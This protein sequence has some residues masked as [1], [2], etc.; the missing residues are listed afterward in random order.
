M[1]G[2]QHMTATKNL[3]VPHPGEFLRDELE[4]RGWNQ[5][6]LAFVIG[7]PETGVNPIITGKRGI[8]PEMARL[9]GDAFDVSPE[10]WMNLQKMYDLE[11]APQPDPA[12]ARRARLQDH[13]PIREMIKRAWLTQ[14][15]NADLLEAECA[16]FFAVASSSQI[17]HLHYSAKKTHYDETPP[18]QLAWLFR[19]RQIATTMVVKPYSEAA[20]RDAIPRLA[21]LMSAPEETRHVAKILAE[22][23]VRFVIVESL[24]GAKIDGV[25][26]WLDAKW[27][28][29]GM[30]L[31]RD[32]I[33]NFWFGLRHEIEHVLRGH[34]K[35]R[36][37]ID[38]QFQP[39]QE[40]NISEE[41]RLANDAAAN[42]C[43]PQGE[44]ENF[45]A[46]VQPYFSEQR[47]LLFAQRRSV[48]PGIVVG[49]LQNKLKRYDFLK[50]H[51]SKIRQF[52]TSSATTDG[53]G[54]NITIEL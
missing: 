34:G 24:P 41:E 10:Y 18:A 22:C 48:H 31:Q 1:K 13:Y 43:V 20:L 42:F 40:T 36:E 8:S 7:V 6:D 16:R 52:V 23:G 3:P 28:V 46:R 12:I 5:R 21:A 45:M 29:I 32:Y 53:W 39:T 37:C 15:E 54:T 2:G 38:E 14:F 49:Q 9:L 51:Q 17:P 35:Q 4:A 11:K 47:V 27:P 33:D 26:L 19:V 30:S 50:K 44:L 25:C